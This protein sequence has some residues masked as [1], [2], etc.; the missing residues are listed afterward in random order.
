V[1]VAAAHEVIAKQVYADGLPALAVDPRPGAQLM[2]YG[3]DVVDLALAAVLLGQWY[4]RR[5]AA[6]RHRLARSG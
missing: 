3:A 6:H 2:Y 5:G 1:L 4:A